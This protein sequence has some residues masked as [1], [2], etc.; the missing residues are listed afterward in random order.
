MLSLS[1]L[2][3]GSPKCPQPAAPNNSDIFQSYLS[4]PDVGESETEC[5][6]LF[7]VRPS[8]S[9]LSKAG[10]DPIQAKL[11][12]Y[13]YIHGGGFGFGAGTDPIWGV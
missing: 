2:I 12:V 13:F 7:V 6:N 10:Y 5:L 3:Q 8:P 9:A 1:S 4:F 11:P